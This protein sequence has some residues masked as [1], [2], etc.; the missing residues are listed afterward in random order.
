ML[1]A[2][3]WFTFYTLAP[4]T[5][6]HSNTKAFFFHTLRCHVR[7]WRD[8]WKNDSK[9]LDSRK[10]THH[11]WRES[12]D[13]W[14]LFTNL[15][16]QRF[17]FWLFLANFSCQEHF[18]SEMPKASV[19]KRGQIRGWNLELIFLYRADR[20]FKNILHRIRK[21]VSF[22]LCKEIEKEFFR[23]IT[24]VGRRKKVWVPIRNRPSDLF[25]HGLICRLHSARAHC[26]YSSMVTHN[27]I[28]SNRSR[29]MLWRC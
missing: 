20:T 14:T 10:N 9:T 28:R 1:I 29:F 22:E 19:L 11:E 17:T 2:S 18:I 12:T 25:K 26:G 23:L 16:Y 15:R 8:I 4:L 3:G 5:R 13:L 21:M 6:T 7:A 27:A 24:S